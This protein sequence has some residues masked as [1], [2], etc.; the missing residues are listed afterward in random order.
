VSRT[1]IL[2]FSRDLG[3]GSMTLRLADR[4]GSLH[5]TPVAT[6]VIA[7]PMPSPDGHRLLYLSV[8]GTSGTGEAH[9]LDLDRSTDTRLTFT[10]DDAALP[11]WS[12]DGRRIAYVTRG[13]TAAQKLYITSAD[14]L[15]APDSI[16]LPAGMAANLRQWSPDG[17]RLLFNFRQRAYAVPVEGTA[18]TPAVL[19][20]STQVMQ[21][22]Q[23]SPDGRW[24]AG[25]AGVG[26][27]V[28]VFV[29]SLTGTP[30][31]WQIS[32]K[33]GVFP[34]WTRGGRELVFEGIEG[35]LMSVDIDTRTGFHPGTPR[36]L[37]APPSRSTNGV[38]ASWGVD[39]AGER[40]Y[41]VEPLRLATEG[42]VEIVSG[43]DALVNRK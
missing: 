43:F 12:P 24:L 21:Q 3:A 6:G 36:P 1:G 31:R 34:R 33:G 14:G 32:S 28:Q 4:S 22:C 38:L 35:Q 19:G 40:F 15:G 37:F 9:V 17:S 18:R 39:A 8:S 13:T 42:S 27:N 7:N 29:Q 25:V 26:A 23:L 41:A 10:G 2:G 20:D 11:V 30:G 16:T 5:G